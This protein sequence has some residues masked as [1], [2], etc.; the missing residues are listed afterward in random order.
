MAATKS[1]LRFRT[2]GCSIKP[3]TSTQPPC[4]FARASRA[5]LSA[6]TSVEAVAAAVGWRG[7]LLLFGAWVVVEVAHM[8]DT[9]S[10]E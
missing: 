7:R 3:G 8:Y 4:S 6:A 9:V 10:V 5:D 2:N 1:L